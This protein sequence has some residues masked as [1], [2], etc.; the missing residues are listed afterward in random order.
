M[1]RRPVINHSIDL[2]I[3]VFAKHHLHLPPFAF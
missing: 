2:A 3:E 1:L